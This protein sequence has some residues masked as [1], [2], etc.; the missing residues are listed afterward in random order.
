MTYYYRWSSN[1][2]TQN[3]KPSESTIDLWKAYVDKSNWRITQLGNGYYQS[4]FNYPEEGWD[5][6]TRRETIE[7][8]EKAIDASIDHYQRKLRMTEGPVVVKTFD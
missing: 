3:Q 7:G 4:E 6:V 5:G 1:S 8:A 2:T